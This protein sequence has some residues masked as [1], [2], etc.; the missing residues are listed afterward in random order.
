V[1]QQQWES[2]S[3]RRRLLLEAKAAEAGPVRQAGCCQ[4]AALV[5]LAQPALRVATQLLWPLLAVFVAGQHVLLL[6]PRR[7]VGRRCAAAVE[8]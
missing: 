7:A 1:A 6:M 2:H 3:H 5:V 8:L 4:Q